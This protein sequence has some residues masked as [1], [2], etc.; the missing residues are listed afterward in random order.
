MTKETIKTQIN[1]YDLTI[2]TGQV[3]RQASGG[4]VVTMGETQLLVTAC[5]SKNARPDFGYFP[6]TVEYRPRS[7]AAGRIPGGFFKREGRP[8]DADTLSA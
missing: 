7:Y 3:L 6:L 5:V 2:E 1:G 4:V 8:Y